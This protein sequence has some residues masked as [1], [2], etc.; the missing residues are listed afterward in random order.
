MR[1]TL[2]RGNIHG[3]KSIK[4][5]QNEGGIQALRV[6]VR[7]T[8]VPP[9]IPLHGRADAIAIAQVNIVAHPDLVPVVN[10]WR[11]RKGH[12]KTI[13]QL[14]SSSVVVEQRCKPP[15]DADVDAHR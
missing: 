2:L 11:S 4:R 10:D 6:S 3:L 5:I 15:A 12:Q 9:A 7:E 13:H 14:N 8:S 1:R